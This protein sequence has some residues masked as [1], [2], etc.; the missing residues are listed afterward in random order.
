MTP[1]VRG[2]NKSHL[3]SYTEKRTIQLNEIIPEQ[4]V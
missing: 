3:T 1:N 4:L 2:E